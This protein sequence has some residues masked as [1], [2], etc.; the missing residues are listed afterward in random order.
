MPVGI[1]LT[2]APPLCAV[3]DRCMS[4]WTLFPRLG[5]WQGSGTRL[6]RMRCSVTGWANEC[7]MPVIGDEAEDHVYLH[8][9]FILDLP[10]L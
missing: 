4:V 10:S 9:P 7:P 1:N 3:R 6:C 8:R 2:S 5:K